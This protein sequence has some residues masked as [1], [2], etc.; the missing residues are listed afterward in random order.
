MV[1]LEVDL[2]YDQFQEDIKEKDLAAISLQKQTID[3][4]SDVVGR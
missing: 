3:L 1:V 2:P 4:V